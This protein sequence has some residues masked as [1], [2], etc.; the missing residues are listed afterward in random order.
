MKAPDKI[1]LHPDIGNRNF[2]RPW[3]IR[4]ANDESVEYIRKDALWK[5]TPDQLKALN[6]I[7][8]FGELSYQ[9]QQQHLIELYQ[10]LKQ[11]CNEQS[12][13]AV[14]G[15]IYDFRRI[16]EIGYSSAKIEFEEI[17]ELDD[18]DKVRVFIIKE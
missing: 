4:P 11:L 12:N 17:P 6:A 1:Y 8:C 7:N 2:I 9:G 14:E 10:Q 5:P 18:G 15:R 16:K 3:L 13:K